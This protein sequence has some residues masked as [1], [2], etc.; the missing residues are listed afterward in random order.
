MAA[1]S[2]IDLLVSQSIQKIKPTL[3]ILILSQF[4]QQQ[5]LKQLVQQHE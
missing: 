2:H 3:S 4:T 1:I 5:P